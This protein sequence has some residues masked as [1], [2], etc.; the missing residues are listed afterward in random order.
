MGSGL[1]MSYRSYPAL[2]EYS[3]INQQLTE[4]GVTAIS[5]IAVL[6]KSTSPSIRGVITLILKARD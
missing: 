2:G 5:Q 1:A 4:L 3:K 6:N